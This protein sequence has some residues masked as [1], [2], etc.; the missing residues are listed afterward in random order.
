MQLC[1][2]PSCGKPVETPGRSTHYGCDLKAKGVQVL[3]SATPSRTSNR[4]Q[5]VRPM[6]DPSWEKGVAGETRPDGSFMPYLNEH[7]E[8]MGVHEFANRRREVEGVVR[9]LKS[10]PHVFE[11]ERTTG[12]AEV[13]TFES[14]PS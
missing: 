1:E 13:Q 12:I 9:E 14:T 6:S 8:E 11:K 3:P 4:R 7:R 2:H 10:N 5:P